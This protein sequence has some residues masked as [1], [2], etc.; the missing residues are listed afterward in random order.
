[1]Q[2]VFWIVGLLNLA[3]GVWM[4]L[5]PESWYHGLP[6][7]VPDTGPLNVHFVRDIGSAFMTIGVA[8]CVAAV[9]AAYRQGVLLA[10]TLF[11]VLHAAVHVADML[12]GRLHQGHWLI[13]LPGVFLPAIVLA[14]LCL[15]R[16]W[17]SQE[18]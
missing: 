14:V 15:P 12:S 1:M 16:W 2:T 4:L 10:A 11:F 17:R 5:S 6:A 9:R 13:D 8:F 7:A 18:E 3:H